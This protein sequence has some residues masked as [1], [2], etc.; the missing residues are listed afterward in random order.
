M[1]DLGVLGDL[2]QARARVAEFGERG[3]R[4]R[5]AA[6]AVDELVRRSSTRSAAGPSLCDPLHRHDRR[7][8]SL[9]CSPDSPTDDGT[10][11]RVRTLVKRFLDKCQ[12]FIQSRR[13]RAVQRQEETRWL[14]AS[15]SHR[16]GCARDRWRA[17]AGRRHGR[18]TRRVRGRRRHRGPSRRPRRRDGGED[19]CVGGARGAVTMDVTVEETG[20]A[21]SRRPSTN[22]AG[23]DILVN[24]AGIEISALIVDVDPDDLRRMLEVNIVGT[25]L[26]I[27]HALPSDEPRR[28]PRPG[29][30]SSTSPRSPRP[31]RSPASPAT[32][33]R[34][35]RSTGSRESPRSSPASSVTACASTASTP[36]SPDRDGIEARRRHGRTR[37]V[38]LARGRRRRRRRATPLGRL[39][40]VVRHGRR[41]RV[42]RL[43]PARSSPASVCPV[44]GGM[45]SEDHVEPAKPVV[46][47]GASGYTGRLVCEYLRELN[48]PFIA[49]GRDKDRMQEVVDQ[50]PGHRHGRARGRRGGARRRGAHR[51]VLRR[52]GRLQHRGPVHQYGPEVVEAAWPRVSL[53]GHDRR[54]GLGPAT[55]RSKWGDKFADEGLLLA[56]SVAQMYTTGE[57][58]ANIALETPGM[59]TLDILVLWK[60]LPDLRLDPDDLHHP[61]GRTGTTSNSK[62]VHG[63]GP[64]RRIPSRSTCPANTRPPLLC[65][66]AAPHIRSGSP[67][68][69]GWRPAG[70]SACQAF[71]HRNLLGVLRSFGMVLEPV[72]TVHT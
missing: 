30:S 70:R 56:P 51:V 33:R 28:R 26:G 23:F 52:A 42:P 15:R 63:M 22:S 45:G 34:N 37:P 43:G 21:R 60:G 32:R 10:E 12:V 16:A 29:G 58:A 36:A 72:V 54:A 19:R 4:R 47:Y 31:S 7:P 24:N 68:T 39:G 18:G 49:A 1:A 50:S 62:Q 25:T 57:I 41:R 5:A 44:D 9:G 3:Q 55:P 61:Q 67:T 13:S 65:R 48:V 40:E 2:P 53:P 17:R 6:H 14:K 27:K 8:L 69:P 66:G 59:D 46:V 11:D 35:P 64:A 20:S 38:A 71:G